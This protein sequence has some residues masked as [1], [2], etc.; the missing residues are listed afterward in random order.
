MN[1]SDTRSVG[2]KY[3]YDIG[4]VLREN[5]QVI[6]HFS[7][8]LSRFRG[9]FTNRKGVLEEENGLLTR[10]PRAYATP[11]FEKT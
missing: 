11:L 9:S 10:A 3:V 7:F 5:D 2:Q 4:F 8:K 6:E 1:E